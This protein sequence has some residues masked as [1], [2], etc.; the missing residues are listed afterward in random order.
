[1]NS[2]SDGKTSS[3]EFWQRGAS[4]RPLLSSGVANGLPP[5]SGVALGFDRL[6]MLALEET[7]LEAALSFRGNDREKF[8]RQARLND[9]VPSVHP[10]EGDPF[11]M[12]EQAGKFF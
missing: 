9:G 6:V 12:Q 10:D 7:T 2:G 1:M 4:P 5:C 3:G 8:R 11:C